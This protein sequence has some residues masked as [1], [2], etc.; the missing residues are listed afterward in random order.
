VA[1]LGINVLTVRLHGIGHQAA[2]LALHA[3]ATPLAQVA[4]P[5]NVQMSQETALVLLITL[6]QCAQHV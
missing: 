2:E 6:D 5:M 3:L 4:I 1:I